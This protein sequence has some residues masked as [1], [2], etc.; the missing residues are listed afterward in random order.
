[1]RFLLNH[2]WRGYL[3][4]E[5]SCLGRLE[6]NGLCTHHWVR[7]A[8]GA[9]SPPTPRTSHASAML[10][11]Q[12]AIAGTTAEA[13]V[14]MLRLINCGGGES[15]LD[16]L[17]NSGDGRE[18]VG[19]VYSAGFGWVLRLELASK[20]GGSRGSATREMMRGPS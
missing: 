8:A 12:H 3:R 16:R 17:S 14:D 2:P 10:D 4:V 1:M 20:S 19:C 11:H 18:A 5:D 7:T 6:S 15:S 9:A 13:W